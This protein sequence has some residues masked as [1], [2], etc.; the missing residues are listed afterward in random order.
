[1][2]GTYIDEILDANGNHNP[3][4]DSIAQAG[5]IANTK[6][7]ADTVGWS[8]KNKLKTAKGAT[9]TV[10]NGTL[11]INNDGSITLNATT[12]SVTIAPWRLATGSTNPA[13]I[14]EESDIPKGKYKIVFVDSNG[15]KNDDIRLQIY[16]TSGALN[17][18]TEV[19]NSYNNTTVTV[20]NTY[21]YYYARIWINKDKTFN[22]VTMYGMLIDENILDESYEPYRNTTA[23]PRDEQA[24]LGA[25]QWFDASR[26]ASGTS[27]TPTITNNGKTINVANST[28]ASYAFALWT[29][30][31]VPNTDYKISSNLTITSGKGGIKI[32]TT[33]GTQ[34]AIS[35]AYTTSGEIEFSFNSGNNTSV[36]VS[37]FS[38]FGTSETGNITFDDFLISLASDTN[39][40]FAPYAMTN[41]QLTDA[42]AFTHLNTTEIAS[43]FTGQNI[44]NA[45]GILNKFGRIVTGRFQFKCTSTTTDTAVGVVTLP[46]ALKPLEAVSFSTYDAGSGATS[47]H[48]DLYLNA[49]GTSDMYLRGSHSADRWICVNFTYVS[50]V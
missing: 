26:Y 37:L 39:R 17:T 33:A 40:T 16:G 19:G 31:L 14:L 28:A 12:S 48:H 4:Q 35:S 25:K 41:K 2:A 7:I 18:G 29:M 11:K 36:R 30:D 32:E 20:D 38:T 44:T 27:A 42:V 15:Q 22:N 6:L 23:F 1:M 21:P 46:D 34:I 50:A 5:V 10:G 45:S 13:S 8:G 49:N 24:V 43:L 47:E 3:L 9:C